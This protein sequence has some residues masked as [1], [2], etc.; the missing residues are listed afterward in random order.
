MSDG[1]DRAASVHQLSF[2]LVLIAGFLVVEVV[3]AA[4]GRSLVLLADAG[5]MLTDVAALATS[6]WAARLSLRPAGGVWTFGLKRAE[7]LAAAVNGVSLAA[8]A[9][10]I[11][12][13]AVRRLVHPGPVRGG[14]VLAVAVLGL[15]VNAA[16]SMVLARADRRGLNVRAAFAHVRS[17]FYAFAGTVVAGVVI[18]TTRAYRADAAAALAVAGLMVRAAW[19]LLRDAGRILLEGAPEEVDLTLVR[20]HLA[21]VEH[22]LDVHDLHAWT[23]TSGLP[24]LSAHVVVADH[25]FATGHAP[26]VLD[27]LQSCLTGHFDVAHATF[28]LEPASHAGH[29][30]GAHH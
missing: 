8:I 24:T 6:V 3:A 20:A 16:A 10:V 25:C 11:T 14:L 21:E 23:V 19:P 7:I 22:V 12:V 5:H 1:G 30:A 17:D 9:L 13:E 15:V 27:A 28:Q 4:L 29:E 2:A 26:Q 18:L